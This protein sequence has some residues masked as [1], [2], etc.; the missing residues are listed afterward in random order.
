MIISLKPILPNHR[1]LPFPFQ[2]SISIFPHHS[3]LRNFGSLEQQIVEN[4][5]PIALESIIIILEKPHKEATPLTNNRSTTLIRAALI[6]SIDEQLVQKWLAFG[7]SKYSLRCDCYL[8]VFD[9]EVSSFSFWGVHE[10]KELIFSSL[11]L[12]LAHH[13]LCGPVMDPFVVLVVG[14][15][16]VAI[17]TSTDFSALEEEDQKEEKNPPSHD[18]NSQDKIILG[19]SLIPTFVCRLLLCSW[20]YKKSQDSENEGRSDD[21]VHNLSYIIIDHLDP[22]QRY[23]IINYPFLLHWRYTR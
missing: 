20:R 10:G 16:G 8:L 19:C 1:P 18:N 5:I 9:N 6:F 15:K 17:K 7:Y 12:L 13:I 21:I 3:P 23:R 22:I 11:E 2:P 4:L 14:V